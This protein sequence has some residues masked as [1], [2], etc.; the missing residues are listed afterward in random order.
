MDVS[1]ELGNNSQFPWVLVEAPRRYWRFSA[2]SLKNV[3]SDC[4]VLLIREFGY[5]YCKLSHHPLRPSF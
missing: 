2:F 1:S 4:F 3:I 5:P